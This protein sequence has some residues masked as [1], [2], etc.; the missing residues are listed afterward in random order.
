MSIIYRGKLAVV[1][2]LL[3]KHSEMI[4]DVS[5][6]G[7]SALFHAILSG[8]LETVVALLEAGADLTSV[9]SKGMTAFHHAASRDHFEILEV[10]AVHPDGEVMIDH[11]DKYG[12]SALDVA[13][14]SGVPPG[15]FTSHTCCL[16]RRSYV[17]SLNVTVK[18]ISVSM[19]IT[20]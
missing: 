13:Q 20:I 7:E 14:V 11:K 3:E 6:A 12:R 9:A 2:K 8:S 10:L 4:N 1:Q 16:W 18:L 17:C 15:V 19:L 5:S